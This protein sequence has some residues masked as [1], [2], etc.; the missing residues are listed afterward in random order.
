MSYLRRRS[1]WVWR[2]LQRLWLQAMPGGASE[3][4]LVAISAAL[5]VTS[6]GFGGHHWRL[7]W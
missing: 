7:W 1:R 4:A 2:S 5:V 3:E 6:G